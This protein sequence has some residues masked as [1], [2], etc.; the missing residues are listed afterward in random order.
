MKT[1][2]VCK[3]ISIQS[4]KE[5]KCIESYCEQNVFSND[6]L[7]TQTSQ[8]YKIL[9]SVMTHKKTHINKQFNELKTAVK[10]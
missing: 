8:T 6:S 4:E 5:G 2:T 10:F 3:L 7:A 1:S 9:P